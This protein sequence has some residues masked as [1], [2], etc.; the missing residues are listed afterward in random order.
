MCIY[1][2]KHT[3]KHTHKILNEELKIIEERDPNFS[4]QRKLEK[5][6]GSRSSNDV[7]QL[8][9]N[10]GDAHAPPLV[11]QLNNSRFQL[12]RQIGG[13]DSDGRPSAQLSPLDAYLAHHKE[14]T[15]DD[16]PVRHLRRYRG[17]MTRNK[18]LE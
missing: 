2:Y 6:E 3:H 12:G 10:D 1:I 7:D 18:F 9:N 17:V 11:H 8:G 4:F 16:L 15:R 14:M 13:G 5:G